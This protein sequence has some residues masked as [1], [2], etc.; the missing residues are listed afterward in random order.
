MSTPPDRKEKSEA[1]EIV[2]FDVQTS[3]LDP[4]RHSVIQFAGVAVEVPSWRELEAL[5]VKIRCDEAKAD[6]EALRVSHYNRE[7]WKKEAVTEA[8]ALTAIT[9]F[10]ER[11]ATLEK[12]SRAGEPYYVAK[13][14]GHNSRFGAEFLYKWFKRAD[15]F[16]PAA[17]YEALDT[18]ALS[19]WS[20]SRLARRESP[21]D[22]KLATL[23][24][25]C[26]IPQPTPGDALGHAR[27]TVQLAKSLLSR[28]RS[29][30]PEDL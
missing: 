4:S 1:E 15:E 11:H 7:L 16:L 30:I 3:G 14:C 12:M 13:L 21:G 6:P 9:D 17:A 24:S 5:E 26:G 27:A 2:V 29:A 23:C 25:W 8:T 18:L 28:L 10:L 20:T 22:H 19:Y